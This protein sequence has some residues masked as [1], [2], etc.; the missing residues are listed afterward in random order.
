M[1]L[2]TS[3]ASL[4]KQ[5]EIMSGDAVVL[6]SDGGRWLL[7]VVDA[8]GHGPGAAEVA[9]KACQHLEKVPLSHG[10]REIV[11]GLHS[12]LRNTRGAAAM[13]CMLHGGSIEGCGVGNVELRVHG[14]DVPVI[15]SPGVLGGSVRQF[16]VFRG[17]LHALTRMVIFSDGISS[18]FSLERMR[19]LTAADACKRIVSEHAHAHDDAT[20]LVADFD[21]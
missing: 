20:V 7:A 10:V 13:V 3:H 4:P 11:T 2:T 8:L 15:L 5:G 9:G 17:Q 6:R 1:K 12:H 18:R 16:R 19:Q 14:D 21:G